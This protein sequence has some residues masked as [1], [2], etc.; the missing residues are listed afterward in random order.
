MS[1]CDDQIMLTSPSSV[2]ENKAFIMYSTI[3]TFNKCY[4]YMTQH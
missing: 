4:N 1:S 2:K 3:T